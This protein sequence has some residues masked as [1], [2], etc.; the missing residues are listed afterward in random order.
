MN[1]IRFY[2]LPI[3]GLFLMALLSVSQGQ[4]IAPSPAPEGFPANGGKAIDQGI[5]CILLLLALVITYTLH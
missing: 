3:V 1:S 4:G 2:A 5:A